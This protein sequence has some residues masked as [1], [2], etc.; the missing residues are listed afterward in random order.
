M[1]RRQ[2]EGLM[3]RVPDYPPKSIAPIR[4]LGDYA[5][6]GFELRSHCSSGLGHS[7]I[8]DLEKEIGLRGDVAVNFALKTSL[9]CPECGAPGGGLEI[10]KT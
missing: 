7:H 3:S 1:T 4:T 8:I 10:R 9:T 2:L 6:A 5:K